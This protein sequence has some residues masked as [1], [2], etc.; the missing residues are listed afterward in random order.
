MCILVEVRLEGAQ[1]AG[2][3]CNRVSFV[4]GQTLLGEFAVESE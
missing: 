4:R 1:A 3:L 2:Q